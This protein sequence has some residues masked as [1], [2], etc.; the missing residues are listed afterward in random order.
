MFVGGS[1][2]SAHFLTE[3]GQLDAQ[4][5]QLADVMPLVGPKC[6]DRREDSSV[7]GLCSLERSDAG[8]QV[9]QR[10]HQTMVDP[11]SHTSGA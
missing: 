5:S 3:V 7:V 4:L 10:G 2:A 9:F 8:F 1:E 6:V 11:S